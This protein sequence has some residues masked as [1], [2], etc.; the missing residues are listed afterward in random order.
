LMAKEAAPVE[1]SPPG[2]EE[3]APSAEAPAAETPA[4]AAEAPAKTPAAIKPEPI[5]EESKEPTKAPLD[6]DF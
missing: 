5:K 1:L 2:E 4:A 6:L 3:A